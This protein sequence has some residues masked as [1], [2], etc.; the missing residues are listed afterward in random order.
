[1]NYGFKFE[2]VSDHITRIIDITGV[3]AYLVEGEDQACLLDTCNGIG[4][5]RALV[6]TLTSKEVFVVLTHGH[7]DHIGGAGLFD[8][9]YMSHLDMP[10]FKKHG[11]MEYR[12][13]DTIDHTN[14]KLEAQDIIPTY[15]GII[16]D[17]P[18]NHIFDLGGVQIKM[19]GVPGHTPGMMCPLIIEDRVIIFGDACGVGVLLFDE[20]SSTVSEYQ[21]ALKHLKTFEDEYDYVYRNHGSFTSNKILLDNVI[22]CTTRILNKSDAHVPVSFHGLALFSCNELA[23]DGHSRKDGKEGNILYAIDKVQ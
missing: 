22:E 21:A 3:S 16:K 4:D 5:I 8:E 15:T 23:Q 19:I 1:M 6:K 9:V 2:K 20:Y 18:D 14:I 13:K 12:I 17:I 11:D 7:L 10:V